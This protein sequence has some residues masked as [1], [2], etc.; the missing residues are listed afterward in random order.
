MTEKEK[1]ELVKSLVLIKNKGMCTRTHWRAVREFR[2]IKPQLIECL[3]PHRLYMLYRA[4]LDN[5]PWYP[6][7]Y[8]DEWN[9][10]KT[11]LGVEVDCI[12]V[13]LIG[14][15]KALNYMREIKYD[16]DIRDTDINGNYY[17]DY[18]NPDGFYRKFSC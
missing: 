9:E 1:N 11:E 13:L 6:D 12:I 14:K 7:G 10:G 8:L 17:A 15:E 18:M 4:L 2:K 5:D 3:S 16:S